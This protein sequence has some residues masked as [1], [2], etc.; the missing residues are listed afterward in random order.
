MVTCTT[1][2]PHR[3]YTNAEIDAAND[4]DLPDLLASLGYP[5]R[6]VGN[7]YTTREM[8]SLQI[9]DRRMLGQPSVTGCAW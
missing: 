1:G 6:R 7:Y 5:V 4:T 9:K 3:H 8:D 2:P